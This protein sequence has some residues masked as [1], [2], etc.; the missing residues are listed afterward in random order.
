MH[1]LDLEEINVKK[2]DYQYHNNQH[3]YFI[4]LVSRGI[5]C[6]HCHSYTKMVHGYRNHTIRHS[7]IIKENLVIVYRQRRYICQYC[8]KTSVEYNPFVNS[9]SKLS[10]KT[11]EKALELLKDYNQTFS[12]VARLLN[13]TPT[14]AQNIFDQYVQV[15]RKKLQ[16]VVC[17]D[18]KYFSSKA[19]SKYICTLIGFKNGVIIDILESRK[20]S[21]LIHYFSQIPIEERKTVKFFSMDMYD[22]Y[23]SAVKLF[24]PHAIICADSF[25]VQKNMNSAVD[26]IR[27]KVMNRY[28]NDK[29]SNEYYL[30]KYK[31]YLLFIDSLKIDETHYHYNCHFKCRMTESKMLEDMLKIDNELRCAYELKELYSVFNSSMNHPDSKAEELN[32]IISAFKISGIASFSELGETLENWKEEIVNSFNT[33]EGRRINNGP[34]EGRNK[35]FD[36]ML[37]LANGYKNFKRFRNRAMYVFNKYENYSDKPLDVE[38]VKSIGKK[39]GKYKKT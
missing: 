33:Y 12:S 30:L 20:K 39:R 6:P 22:N 36:I 16:K 21:A 23:R 31:N 26:R 24:F 25:H 35:Y 34:I 7:I 11:V 9:K 15:E 13:I 14:E 27:C 37:N 28:K 4:T 5:F 38:N 10:N 1:S 32:S 18:E 17:I 8:G 3:Y 29:K 2:I 19:K